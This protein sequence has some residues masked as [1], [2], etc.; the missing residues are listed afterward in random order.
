MIKL[1]SFS[2]KYSKPQGK[3]T[4]KRTLTCKKNI[5]NNFNNVLKYE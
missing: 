2:V 1:R 4:T 5:V 3:C